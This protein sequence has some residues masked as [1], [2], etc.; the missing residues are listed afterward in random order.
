VDVR[1]TMMIQ[2]HF[3]T[4]TRY[5]THIESYLHIRLTEL[6][7]SNCTFCSTMF[8]RASRRVLPYD[9]IK[10]LIDHHAN[11]GV[12]LEVGGAEPT[13]HPHFMDVLSY[14]NGKFKETAIISNARAFHSKRMVE[15]LKAIP[16]LSIKASLHG[17]TA[18]IQDALTMARGSFDQAVEGF[19]NLI[20]A[21]IPVAVNMVIT[22]L[23][24]DHLQ[25]IAKLLWSLG[26]RKIYVSGLMLSGDTRIDQQHAVRYADMRVPLAHLLDFT[27]EKKMTVLLEK[28]PVCVAPSH[29]EMF[30]L[31]S[32]PPNFIKVDQCGQCIHNKE[33]M[34]INKDYLK[35][36]YSADVI[37][38]LREA[39]IVLNA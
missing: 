19:R 39:S 23:N 34:G 35:Q 4:E 1:P 20:E 31:E 2:D 37:P 6:C 22:R 10:D 7:N 18:Q 24:K 32:N 38:I 29:K 16:N 28:L 5:G 12:I 15:K 25:D 30:L 9:Y 3:Y 11:K 26:I 17:H 33:C 36:G 21:N 14:A 13:I 8:T 27:E